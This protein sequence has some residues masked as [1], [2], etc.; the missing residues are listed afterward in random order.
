M[1]SYR[2]SGTCS[3]NAFSLTEEKIEAMESSLK[4]KGCLICGAPLINL[5]ICFECYDQDIEAGCDPPKFEDE[6]LSVRHGKI[7]EDAGLFPVKYETLLS[8]AV[9]RRYTEVKCYVV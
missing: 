4:P 2:W 7:P 9:Q 6:L 8:K 1:D 3:N 5:Y